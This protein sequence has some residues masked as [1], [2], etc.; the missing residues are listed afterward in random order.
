[1]MMHVF[2]MRRME[3]VHSVGRNR[4]HHLARN[5]G[6]R[7]DDRA[8]WWKKPPMSTR[9]T[10]TLVSS[11][12]FVSDLPAVLDGWLLSPALENL[13]EL[14]FCYD[15]LDSPSPL[16]PR[17]A[18]RFSTLRVADF[19]CCQFPDDAAHQLH[20][21]NLQR[22]A[23]GSVI[24]SEDSLHAMLAGCPA[25]DRWELKYC[26]EA[27]PKAADATFR[28]GLLLHRPH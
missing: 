24:I 19:G 16:M 26:S 13:Q 14:K 5:H 4:H 12:M 25:L 7:V 2:Q 6:V 28:P 20:F 22:L 10:C 17:S 8:K 18:L 11:Y 21:P 1:M 3:D 9:S 23:L 15:P 27:L